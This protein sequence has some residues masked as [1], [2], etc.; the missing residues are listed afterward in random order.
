M[1]TIRPRM[2][3]FYLFL[4]KSFK[5]LRF[6]RGLVTRLN[7]TKNPPKAL[8]KTEGAYSAVN[9]LFINDITVNMRKASPP[10]QP[11]IVS[12]S[13]KVMGTWGSG[14]KKEKGHQMKSLSESQL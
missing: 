13:L 6:Q 11:V 7:Q 10:K 14:L 8:K 12:V 5:A 1:D 4:L 2:A 3:F 9:A